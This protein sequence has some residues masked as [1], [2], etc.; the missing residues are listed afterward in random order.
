MSARDPE[1]WMNG[2]IGPDT[3]LVDG[4]PLVGAR[5]HINFVGAE[6]EDDPEN[7][8]V[9]VTIPTGGGG[10]TAGGDLTGTSSSQ[11]V[12]K[13]RGATVNTAAG[14]LTPG[15]VL[16]V[17]GASTIDYGAVNLGGG[18]GHVTG[19][20]PIANL[21][22][23]LADGA[24]LMRSSGNNTFSQIA[25]ANVSGSAA[26]A[27]SK[28]AAPGLAG[29]IVINSTTLG[30]SSH[31]S[32]S[33]T[34]SAGFTGSSSSYVA[35]GTN[36]A[37]SGWVR[38]PYATAQN[39]LTMRN[40][41]NTSDWNLIGMTSSTLVF[42]DSNMDSIYRAFGLTLAVAFSTGLDVVVASGNSFRATNSVINMA[43][44]IAGDQRASQPFRLKKLSIAQNSTSTLTLSAAQYENPFL[45]ATGAAGGAFIWQGPAA[46]GAFFIVKNSNSASMTFRSGASGGITIAAGKTA[47]LIHNGTN[48]ELTGAIA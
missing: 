19:T 46:E 24:V 18:A 12:S 27:A 15:N 45:E 8:A 31:W 26:I 36:P 35:M 43:Q 11:T 9:N 28:I 13:V 34:G 48:Y 20:L 10:F 3:V 30:A 40:N 33:G 22:T 32:M 41:D 2:I 44:P 7:D 14:A 4:D 38:V 21:A 1:N 16:K 5:A 6:Q 25:D 17:T 39:I 47:S 23:A 37:A 29:Q 42:G